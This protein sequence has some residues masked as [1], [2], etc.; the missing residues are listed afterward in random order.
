MYNFQ[1]C[2]IFIIIIILFLH[3]PWVW[4]CF[5]SLN[6]LWKENKAK[7]LQC[8]P[9]PPHETAWAPCNTFGLYWL[10]KIHHSLGET[11]W[12]DTGGPA[13]VVDTMQPPITVGWLAWGGR[14]TGKGR[15]F[16]GFW[17]FAGSWGESG[18]VTCPPA[19]R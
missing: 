3:P 6:P 19:K 1:Q 17:C 9:P 10:E 8:R 4:G 12:N 5:F 7:P 15:C 11:S 13:R 14:G 16:G 2:V 18:Q